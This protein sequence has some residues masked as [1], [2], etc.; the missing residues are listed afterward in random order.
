MPA[1]ERFVAIWPAEERS[2][3]LLLGSLGHD[4]FLSL[5]SRCFLYLR[6][7]ECDGVAASVLESLALGIPVV[8]S[9]NGRRPAGVISYNDT[10]AADMVDKLRFVRE[11]YNEVKAGLSA[12]TSVDNV[13]RMADWLAGEPIEEPA[14]RT[15]TAR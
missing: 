11:Q 5:L 15:I 2:S 14:H 9:E 12:D 10:S 8:A 4:E 13:S 7:P 6:T 1:A 3:L